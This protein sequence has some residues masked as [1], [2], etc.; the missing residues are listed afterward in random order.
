MKELI[1]KLFFPVIGLLSLIWFLIRV[2]PKPSRAAYPCM[3]AAAP[4]ASTFIVYFL[5]L[6]SSI[7]VFKKA[8]KYLHESRYILFSITFLLGI[9]L[10]VSSYLKT[11]KK[12]YAEYQE[13]TLEGPN[14]P[15]GEGKGIFPGRV[16][17][18]Y[19]PDA[20]YENCP[21][22]RTN[23]WSMDTNTDQSVVN[24]MVS[25]GLHKLTG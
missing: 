21:N 7:F 10:G 4:I 11:D 13:K 19:D 25:D 16:V 5:G 2:I 1:K 17:W 23:Y 6:T 18:M 12:V 22:T 9:I 15:M 14:Q 8:K 3:R 24:K 20:T